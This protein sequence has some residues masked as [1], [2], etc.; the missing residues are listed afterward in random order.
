[1]H[2]AQNYHF[3]A[4]R[5]GMDEVYEN[6]LTAM[7]YA[8]TFSQAIP[9]TDV[10]QLADGSLVCCHD[11]TLERTGKGDATLLSKPLAKMSLSEL[12]SIDAG[13]GERVPLLSEILELMKDK[14]ER[15]LYLEI[16]KA[17]LAEVL[18]ILTTFGVLDRIRFVHKEQAFCQQ[19]QTLLPQAP[20]MS[21][22]SGSPQEIVQHFYA[23]A[24]S[25]FKG[26]SEVQIHFPATMKED[27]LH[28]PL[29]RGFLQ[30]AIHSTEAHDAVLQVCPLTPSSH[31]LRYLYEEGVRSFVSNAPQAFTTMMEQALGS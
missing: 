22:C 17:P 14:E 19:I 13:G 9:E 20:T 5:G 25:G 23:L 3:Q 28:S 12:E 7:Q 10:R 27:E 21:W 8:W 31:L 30:E 1:M 15:L 6:T 11:D 24:E 18:E 16:K 29:P 2:N 4:H 26:L